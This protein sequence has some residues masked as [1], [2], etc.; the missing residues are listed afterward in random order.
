MT[1]T[2]AYSSGSLNHGHISQALLTSTD[3][4]QTLDF[5]HIS[6]DEINDDAVQ[7]LAAIGRGD[8]DD[9]GSVAR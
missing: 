7:E 3:D 5:S 6:I 2:A 9:E 1:S 4:G 8:E